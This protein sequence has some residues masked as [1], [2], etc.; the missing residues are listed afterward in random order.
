LAGLLVAIGLLVGCQVDLTVGIR[1]DEDGSGTVTVAAGLDDDALARAGNLEGQLRVEDLRAAGW[2]VTAPAREDEITWV[3]AS[4]DFSSPGQAAEVLAEVTGPDGAFR[5]FEVRVDDGT[6]GSDYSVTGTVDLTDGPIAFGDAELAAVLG[7]D[8][9]GGTLQAIEREEGRP[10][11]EM[12][13]FGVV[14]E[15]P[16]DSS[17]RTFSFTSSFGEE[18]PTEI[19][20]STSR[21]N[22]WATFA[23]WGLVALV[24]VIVLV[25]LRQAFRRIN[26]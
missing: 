5:D 11:A 4:K 6:F 1:V 15:L 7:G 18:Q 9:F 21:R 20:A 13:Q 25:V 23:I 10:V 22:G 3:R 19:A 12:V 14:V 17:S 26:R 2:A 24:G 8:P 16:D